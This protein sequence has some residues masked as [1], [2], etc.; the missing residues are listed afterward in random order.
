MGLISLL[1]RHLRNRQMAGYAVSKQQD[2]LDKRET[3]ADE[4]KRPK[5]MDP[6]QFSSALNQAL[7]MPGGY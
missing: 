3:A 2:M 5:P 6:N 1:I 4:R 7:R